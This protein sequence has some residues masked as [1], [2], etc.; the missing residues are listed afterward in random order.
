VV[1]EVSAASRTDPALWVL[2]NEDEKIGHG[3]DEPDELTHAQAVTIHRSPG[4]EHSAWSSP[5][6][7]R[8]AELAAHPGPLSL[9][10]KTSRVRSPRACTA[11][12]EV[13][14]TALL[15]PRRS[16]LTWGNAGP[17][18]GE[19]SIADKDEVGGSSPPRPTIRPLTSRNAAQPLELSR[20][21]LIINEPTGVGPYERRH[22]S[23]TSMFAG[24]WARF[25][26]AHLCCTAVVQRITSRADVNAARRV[27]GSQNRGEAWVDVASVM[28]PNWSRS[29]QP[30]LLSRRE[31]RLG[32][33]RIMTCRGR[34]GGRWR[35]PRRGR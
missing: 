15:R 24:H 33:A 29:D 14:K 12:N 10:P 9:S 1:S 20:L 21:P 32:P 7:Q 11:S 26:D 18:S 35:P 17:H 25:P 23:L 16:R 8:M 31:E 3:F 34:A 4:G 28:P 22:G 2:L 6:D 27:A 5:G 19:P 30:H 13:A